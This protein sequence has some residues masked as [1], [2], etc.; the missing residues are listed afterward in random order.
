MTPALRTR[1]LKRAAPV[2]CRH[3]SEGPF[4][5]SGGV[6]GPRLLRCDAHL[7]NGEGKKTHK[8]NNNPNLCDTESRG[9]T[10]IVLSC[11]GN[12]V[13]DYFSCRF[14]FHVC[15]SEFFFKSVAPSG[16]KREKKRGGKKLCRAADRLRSFRC[17]NTSASN[18]STLPTNGFC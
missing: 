12:V 2:V 15:L 13:T 6:T 14:F 11:R 8:P 16:T 1:P 5:S 9:V 3:S 10:A 7:T 4:S 18:S 17:P